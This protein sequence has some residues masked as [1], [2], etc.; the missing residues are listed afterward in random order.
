[1]NEARRPTPR[2]RLASRAILLAVLAVA[3]ALGVGRSRDSGPPQLPARPAPAGEAFGANTG[4]LFNGRPYPDAVI[5]AQ[6]T[7]LRSTGATLARADAAWEATEP[8]A[9][10]GNIHRYDWSF[11]DRIAGALAAHGLTWLPTID[12]AAP[13]AQTIHGQNHSAPDP[14]EYAA[15]AAAVA[16]RYGAHGTF[17][18]A[19]P[20]IPDRPVDTFEIWNEPDNPVF[21]VPKPDAQT[22]ARLYVKARQAIDSVDPGAR[23]IVGGLTEAA[24]FLPAMLRALPTLRNHIDGVAVHPYGATPDEV[25]AKLAQ[26]RQALRALGMPTVPLYVTEFGWTTSPRGA[27]DYLPERRR[28]AFI[29]QALTA[30][31][32][33]DCG[34]VAV[35]LYAW[36]TP[37][38]DRANSEDWFGIHPPGGGSSPDTLAFRRGLRAATSAGPAV[39]ACAAG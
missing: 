2:R 20:Q 28:P 39:S 34:L 29:Q 38:R 21:W 7:A 10:L 3:I 17:W 18:R 31:G 37:E 6:L 25:L 5:Q 12:Y 15:Y 26:A 16:A 4:R 32:H 13:W 27:L 33:T 14:A 11:D 9:P 30:L 24:T 22:Y 36:V 19:N 35:L 23:V 1:V 8:Q